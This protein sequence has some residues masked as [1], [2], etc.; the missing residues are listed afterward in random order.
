M[1]K[2]TQA[3]LVMSSAIVLAGCTFDGLTSSD[4]YSSGQSNDGGY[5]TSQAAGNGN[6]DRYN[7]PQPAQPN[8]GGYTSSSP[9]PAGGGYSSSQP[10]P[11]LA[12]PSPVPPRPAAS[13]PAPEDSGG[14]N[15]SSGTADDTK[16]KVTQKAKVEEKVPSAEPRMPSADSNN[17]GGYTTS[18]QQ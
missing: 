12:A 14:Y 4:Y 2:M 6:R 7:R 5:M 15:T 10:A 13:A 11:G 1:K 18:E 17:S 16:A 8:N 9:A 3:M